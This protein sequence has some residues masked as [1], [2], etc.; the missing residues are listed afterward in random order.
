MPSGAGTLGPL[1]ALLPQLQKRKQLS[2]E[3]QRQL[4]QQIYPALFEEQAR[5]GGANGVQ[6]LWRELPKSLKQDPACCRPPRQEP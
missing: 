3:E 1:L 6:T 5:T 2:G 4:Q